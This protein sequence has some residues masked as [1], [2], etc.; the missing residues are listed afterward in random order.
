MKPKDSRN[1]PPVSL[2]F[3]ILLPPVVDAT[4][5]LTLLLAFAASFS[6]S[7]C[8]SLLHFPKL[9]TGVLIHQAVLGGYCIERR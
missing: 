2:P 7:Q 6:K 1:P 3:S 5:T 8:S 9:K 4:R